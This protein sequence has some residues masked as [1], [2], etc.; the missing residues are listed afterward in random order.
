[1]C[2]IALYCCCHLDLSC[3][4]ALSSKNGCGK[5]QNQRT[6]EGAE[7]VNLEK[8]TKTCVSTADKHKL[9]H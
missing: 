1:M 5:I 2:I 9:G 6:W 8:Y 3:L 7:C 4:E